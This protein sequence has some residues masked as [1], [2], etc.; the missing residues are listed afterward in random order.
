MF[1]SKSS[2]LYYYRVVAILCILSLLMASMPP[3][4]QA[5]A[6][7]T[8]QTSRESERT[9]S[10]TNTQI[11]VSGPSNTHI[12]T[13]NGNLAYSVPLLN[14]PN[15][16]LPIALGISYIS[17]WRNLA[18]HY[19][20]GWQLNYNMFYARIEK[21]DIVVVWEQG[22]D[23]F[24]KD[25]DSFLPPLDTYNTL[26]AYQPGKYVLTTK[27][28]MTYYFD[29][30]IHKRVTK[31]QDPNGNTLIFAYDD[32]MR[33][34][35]ITDAVGREI[36]FSY[37]NGNLT[38]ITDSN[39][40]PNRSIQLQYDGTN[41]L[42]G[43]TDALGN[44]TSYGYNSEHFLTTIT[45]PL[46]TPTAISYTDGAVTQVSDGLTTRTFAYDSGSRITTVTDA[47]PEGNRTNR[48]FYDTEERITIIEDPIGNR[49][50]L[51]WDERSNLTSITDGNGNTTTYTYDAMGN[52]LSVT[53]ALGNTTTY[54][55]EDAYS[56]LA[57][58]A[59]ANG[60][61]TAYTYD[62]RGNLIRETDPLGHTTS[63]AYNSI[64]EPI[65]RTDAN[66]NI[67]AY[68]YDNAGNLITTLYP[69]GS[70]VSY[71]YD[72]IGNMTGMAN[73]NARVLY[74]YDAL[75]RV[76][77]V[78]VASHG[79]SISYAYDARGNRARMIDP[80]GGSTAYEYDAAGRLARLTNPLGQV[81]TYAYDGQSRLVS[82]GYQNGTNAIYQYDLAGGLLSLVNRK[83]LGEV[84]S[85]Y[86]HEYDAAGNRT[87]MTEAD[88]G[89]TVYG[90][91]N[92]YQLTG[93]TYPDGST[94]RYSY[95]PVGNRLSMADA[96]GT[97][98][99]HY[100]DADRLI[101][102]GTASYGWNNNGNM[103]WKT[104]QS[105][106]TSYAYDYENRL[107][108]VTLPDGSTNIFSYYPDSKCLSKTDKSG[109]TAYRFYDSFNTLLETNNSGTT[110]AR[111]TSAGID[112][113]ISM[114]R[115]NLSY[116]YHRDSLGSVSELTDLGQIVA[117]TY[118]Y[119]VF[120][121][122]KDQAIT[123]DYL[124]LFTG[125]EWNKEIN[126]YDY[127]FRQY[128]PSVGRFITKDTISGKVSDPLSISKYLYVRNNPTKFVDP[129]GTTWFLDLITH[130]IFD[131]I[132]PPSLNEGEFDPTP[133]PTPGPSPTPTQP[134]SSYPTPPPTETPEPTPTPTPGT[135]GG[136]GGGIESKPLKNVK[137]SYFRQ[138]NLSHSRKENTPSPKTSLL[139]G[140]S[141]FFL[142]KAAFADTQPLVNLR[143]ILPQL[144]PVG[145]NAVAITPQGPF[146]VNSNAVEVV[147]I[148]F[149]DPATS[150]NKATVFATKT[151]GRTY[152]H[153]YHNCN[154]F[155]GYTLE[156]AAA[157][158]LSGVLPGTTDA[159]WFWYLSM[160]K[161]KLVEETFIFAVFVDE[162]TKTF[163]V[164]SQW[165]TDQYSVPANS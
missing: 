141:T 54:T 100:D 22:A 7:S 140:I 94:V 118:R 29:N 28:G 135:G 126:L 41:N 131:L 107:I 114:D 134:P 75:N 9:R 48:Y 52:L 162:T 90:Y 14:L 89:V 77:Q 145:T 147:A 64:G 16:S 40:T 163:T 156:T 79:K 27:E 62:G 144:G 85:S 65:S 35:S 146:E 110:M 38:A 63:Y 61:T 120:G 157:L 125:R 132:F 155:H 101:S 50:S 151:I 102:A 124:Y 34:T 152:D 119:D 121:L 70:T 127:R 117:A 71:T 55:Y 60:H 91:D 139:E 5:Y 99:Y 83:S 115:D 80:D 47:A 105:G 98:A 42:I 31:R 78:N 8:T 74:A 123:T 161:D 112:N 150:V 103:I 57:S 116:F 108:R 68:A 160:T 92:L 159:P 17:G 154:L 87:Q 88:G 133:T 46:G 18:S 49:I 164:D 21:G 58:V 97:T 84:I 81:T 67:T 143:D 129:Y 12:S 93:V 82:K 66:G 53:D 72:A 95:D 32:N 43:I 73:A 44:L 137:P 45:P 10:N 13:W 165:L 37:V 69:D 25:G 106:T 104:D 26:R 130:E 11:S 36:E 111:Y 128:D 19:G 33:L 51:A 30:P 56:H 15:R 1:S 122:L 136:D 96:H 109:T 24:I 148:D 76:T 113:W 3:Y 2:H 86:A 142:G 59:N 6:S 149:V 4:P 158:S 138:F 23:K 20:Y 39:I 153:D